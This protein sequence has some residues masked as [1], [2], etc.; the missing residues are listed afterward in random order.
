MIFPKTTWKDSENLPE[1]WG[2]GFQG[3]IAQYSSKEQKLEVPERIPMQ[4]CC[5][6][7]A[8]FV[9]SFQAGA[10]TPF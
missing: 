5:P 1:L 6:L 4:A 9:D 8:L 3:R 7:K 10:N 2:S